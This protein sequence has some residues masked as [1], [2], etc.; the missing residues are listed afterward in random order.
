MNNKLQLTSVKVVPDI[1]KVFKIKCMDTGLTLQKFLN[2][3]LFLY[4]SDKEFQ[5]MIDNTV[6]YVSGSGGL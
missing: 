3:S 5:E 2:R 1:Y 6:N 4:N